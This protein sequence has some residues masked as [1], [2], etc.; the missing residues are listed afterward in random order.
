[1]KTAAEQLLLSF[2]TFAACFREGGGEELLRIAS[3]NDGLGS[4]RV[5]ETIVGSEHK[6]WLS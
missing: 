3:L 2:Q 5:I 6:G 4:M 1:M